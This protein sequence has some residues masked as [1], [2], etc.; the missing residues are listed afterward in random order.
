[1][2]ILYHHRTQADD[3]QAVHIR[4]LQSAWR[5]LGHE[6]V[7]FSLVSRAAPVADAA[8]SAAPRKRSAWSA[9]GHL[10]RFA[11][12]LAEYSYTAYARPRLFQAL[13]RERP[14]FLYERYAFGNAAGVIAARR[15]RV[16]IVLEVNSPMVQELSRTRGLS[17][18][19]TA[20][21]MERF[22]LR[23]ATRVCAVS[24]VLADMLAE[25]GVDRRRMFVTPNG[26]HLE[27]FEY[28]D[29]EAARQR[30]RADLRLP[31]NA[32]ALGFV[33]YYRD[34]HRL[35]LVIDAL[36]RLPDA[37]LCLVGEGPAH[38]AL[39]RRA[40]ERGVEARVL[41]AGTRPHASIPALLPAFD[42]ALVPAINPYASPLKLHEYM[43]A[44]LA[45]IAPDQ[46][47]LREVLSHGKNAWLVPPGEEGAMQAALAR[48]ADDAAL[49]AQLGSAAR[50][51][52]VERGLTW[53]GNAAR[54][55]REIEEL[56]ARGE[57][58]W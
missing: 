23:E 37:V 38:D 7:E 48:L 33:G 27:Q 2:K 8:G 49:R 47:N 36:G 6:L 44:A 19:R 45:I 50:R 52:I 46:P 30:A 24:G 17:F 43:A 58:A 28:G 26:V 31:Q 20:D 13:D 34:W 53:R 5:E 54:V 12:E 4:S 25:L 21:K 55:V 51:T 39:R 35:D 57:S 41:F 32:L 42:I 3:G 22:I 14:D 56:R 11:R 40:S 15:A 1:V 18:A 9:L 29:V 10:P 16:P